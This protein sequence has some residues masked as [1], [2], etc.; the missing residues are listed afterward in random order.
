[1]ISA[2]IKKHHSIILKIGSIVFIAALS[3]GV[4]LAASAGGALFK[5]LTVKG[6]IQVKQGENKSVL[7]AGQSLQS[8]D[9]FDIS[10]GG[11]IGL[12]GING[13]S[14]ELKKPGH[15]KAADLAKQYSGKKEGAAYKFASYIADQMTQQDEEESN[16]QNYRS[17]MESTG[18]VERATGE[19]VNILSKT[20]ELAG[21]NSDKSKQ[22]YKTGQT[23]DF[24]QPVLALMPRTG[25]IIDDKI[26]CY[27]QAEQPETMWQIRFRDRNHQTLY[28][29]KTA[30][31]HASINLASLR[32][33]SDDCYFWSVIPAKADESR[34][35]EE[36]ALCTMSASEQRAIADTVKQ[37]SAELGSLKTATA[38]LILAAFY[39]QNELYTRT[40]A[41]F[42][43][44]MRLA[45]D[46]EDIKAAFRRFR[47]NQGLPSE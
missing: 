23:T 31:N 12:I 37:L 47:A 45:P 2:R 7:R 19:N 14:V 24:D 9:E 22:L 6:Q 27:W 16:S 26:D 44:A 40:D 5:V 32:L 10:T 3:A 18:A 43:E 28:E 34:R 20:I 39:E 21:G 8:G 38:Q 36:Y 30:G 1:M 17:K 15:Y 4:P 46:V 11:F 41:C 13:G 25:K 33:D 29:K 35:S 42:R